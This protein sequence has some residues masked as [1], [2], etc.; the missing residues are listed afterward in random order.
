LQAGN[1]GKLVPGKNFKFRKGSGAGA[2]ELGARYTYS[3]LSNANI[4]GGNF[5]RFT[6][7]LSWYPNAHFRFEINYGHG[8]LNTS[9]K[10][11]TNFYQLR[12]QLEL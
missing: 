1:L 7:A 8:T 4:S 2:F 6:T 12:I 5:G 10:G 11:I 3:N 9:I